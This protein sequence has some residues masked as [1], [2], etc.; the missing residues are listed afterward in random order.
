M[1]SCALA[2]PHSTVVMDDL[3]GRRCAQAHGLP[4]RGTLGIVVGA[5]R[6]GEIPSARRVL[7]DLR[8][9]GM[10]LSD[11]VLETALAEVGE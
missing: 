4:V 10:Y 5:R 7:A 9:A 6:R 2:D 8:A 1:I 11:S 3:A